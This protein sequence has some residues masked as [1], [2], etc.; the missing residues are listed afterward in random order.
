MKNLIAALVIFQI[1]GGGIA[2]SV[3]HSNPEQPFF[4]SNPTI[5]SPMTAEEMEMLSIR[6][7]DDAEKFIFENRYT[8]VH[9]RISKDKI[10]NVNVNQ[11]NTTSPHFYIAKNNDNNE[12]GG[13]T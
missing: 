9:H 4:V 3:A 8:M 1:I 13:N 10:V 12:T 2:S 7:M 6:D 11:L 5:I